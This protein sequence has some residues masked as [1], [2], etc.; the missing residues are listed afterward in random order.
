MTAASILREPDA[1]GAERCPTCGGAVETPYCPTC[2]EQRA[3]D[4]HYSLRHLGEELFETLFHA[5]GRAIRTFRALIARPGALTAAYMR[6]ERKPYVAPLQLFFLANIVF[7]VWVGITH[8][9]TFSTPLQFHVGGMFYSGLA[10][11]LVDARLAARHLTYDSYAA[12]FD[13]AAT[14]QAKSLI[15]LMVPMLA[16][17]TMLVTLPRRRSVTQHVVFALHTMTVTLLFIMAISLV[18]GL[19]ESAF[20]HAGVVARWQLWDQLS[21][22]AIMIALGAYTHRALRRAYGLS[23]TDATVR[24]VLFTLAFIPTVFLYRGVLFFTTFYTT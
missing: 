3:T 20:V 14:L 4:R 12:T 19:A 5:D 16:L 24:A 7:F 6:G 23:S 15:I 18:L 10:H 9:N 8:I 17:V 21:A 22:L 2:G 13:H 1:V 11:R